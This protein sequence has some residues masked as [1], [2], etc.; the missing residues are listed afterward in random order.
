MKIGGTL[1]Y[2]TCALNKKENDKVVDKFLDIHREFEVVD[3]LPEMTHADKQ[4]NYF[5]LFPQIN[6]TD[7]FFIAKLERKF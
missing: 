1:I 7:G 6:G 4:S 5:T 3:C 2:S